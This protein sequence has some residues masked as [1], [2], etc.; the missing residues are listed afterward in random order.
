MEEKEAQHSLKTSE[1]I[2]RLIYTY[3]SQLWNLLCEE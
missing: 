3:H 1:N 2:E